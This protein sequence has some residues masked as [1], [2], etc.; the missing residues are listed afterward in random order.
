MKELRFKNKLSLCSYRY[1]AKYSLLQLQLKSLS[2]LE[3]QKQYKQKQPTVNSFNMGGKGGI[4]VSD[5]PISAKRVG[6]GSIY[7]EVQLSIWWLTRFTAA[8]FLHHFLEVLDIVHWPVQA[9]P[10]PFSARDWQ[11]LWRR[12][13]AVIRMEFLEDFQG[14]LS[15]SVILTLGVG[16]SFHL[17]SASCVQYKIIDPILLHM[18]YLNCAILVAG[19]VLYPS[20]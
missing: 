4:F 9:A 18:A 11:V 5:P 20:I 12:L 7:R 3:Q 6:H 1:S 15:P 14:L 16:K 13:S 17:V 8:F 19:V 10:S 2:V